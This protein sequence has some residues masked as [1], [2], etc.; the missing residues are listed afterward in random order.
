MIVLNMVFT[1][2][3]VCLFIPTTTYAGQ[4]YTALSRV[5]DLSS[6]RLTSFA[7]TRITAHPKAIEFY[8]NID[9][10]HKASLNFGA[11]LQSNWYAHSKGPVF[12]IN[13]Q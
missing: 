10:T 3:F 9:P 13:E 11:T 7:P 4:S 5:R 6:L 2:L 12:A 1:N 8:K